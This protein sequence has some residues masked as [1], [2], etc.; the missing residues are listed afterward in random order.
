MIVGAAC[1]RSTVCKSSSRKSRICAFVDVHALAELLTGMLDAF[2]PFVAL[3]VPLTAPLAMSASAVLVAFSS[4]TC[5]LVMIPVVTLALGVVGETLY[6]EPGPLKTVV[7]RSADH[8]PGL[9]W[10]VPCRLA[11]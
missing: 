3:A 7:C 9:S 6:R 4:A 5:V 2:V 1:V 8:S 11:H 10:R